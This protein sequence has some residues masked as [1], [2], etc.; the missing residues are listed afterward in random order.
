MVS[1]STACAR[2]A[3]CQSRSGNVATIAAL[4]MPM[5][6]GATALAV[7]IGNLTLERR[8]L[9]HHADLAAIV[10]A[11]ALH[12]PIGAVEDYVAANN[13]GFAVPGRGGALTVTT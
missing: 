2:M 6:I 10:A 1:L 9:Q 5:V 4:A 11:S 3:R 13:L 7:D 8:E 12:D